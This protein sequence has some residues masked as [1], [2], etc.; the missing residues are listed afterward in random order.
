LGALTGSLT[1]GRPRR[2]QMALCELEEC[3]LFTRTLTTN[4]QQRI[5]VLSDAPV[6]EART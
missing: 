2:V 1:T 6:E 3:G 5:T 4:G